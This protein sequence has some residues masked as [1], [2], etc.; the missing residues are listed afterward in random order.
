MFEGALKNAGVVLGNLLVEVILASGFGA[1]D[2]R[3]VANKDDRG[4][5]ITSLLDKQPGIPK[6][7]AASALQV[8]Y[9]V[10]PGRHTHSQCRWWVVFVCD[11]SE[12]KQ[13]FSSSLQQG[14]R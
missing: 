2:A 4:A 12:T 9:F 1:D 11:W 5:C 13:P 14:R 3:I 7:I 6:G 10:V 8:V